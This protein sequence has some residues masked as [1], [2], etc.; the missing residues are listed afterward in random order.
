MKHK[1]GTRLMASSFAK[2]PDPADSMY[3]TMFIATQD[4]I[5]NFFV[6]SEKKSV[7]LLI[8][9]ELYKYTHHN[10]K[11]N[12]YCYLGYVKQPCS[13]HLCSVGEHVFDNKISY[14]AWFLNCWT[15]Q[16]FFYPISVIQRSVTAKEN[17]EL[18][19]ERIFSLITKWNQ[20]HEQP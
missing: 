1:S 10:K 20:R 13:C 14:N 9:G 2:G 8:P 19:L 4:E 3:D 11:N 7:K 12:I 18:E 17:G 5:E 6:L 15:N 16:Y